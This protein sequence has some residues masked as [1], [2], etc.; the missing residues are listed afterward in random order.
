MNSL[1]SFSNRDLSWLAFNR[2]VLQE[3][4]DQTVPLMQRLRFL[5]IY[6]NNNDEFIKV[7]LANLMRLDRNAKTKKLVLPGKYTPREVISLINQD[8]NTT[9]QKFTE[10]YECLLAEM[11]KA[12]IFVIDETKLNTEQNQFCRKYFLDVVSRRLLPLFLHKTMRLPFLPDTGVY[13]AVCLESGATG[14]KR[15]AILQT[16][17]NSSCPRFVELPSKK[18]Q[19]DI[20]LLDDIIRLC[21]DD[22][23]FMFKYERATAYMFKLLRDASLSLENGL[24]K[25]LVEKM[26]KGLEERMHG[27]PVRFIYDREMP[28]EL[29]R[30]LVSKLAL[31]PWAVEPGRRYHMM[32][33]LM[34]FPVIR[35]DLEVSNTPPLLHPGLP[36]FS[37]IFQTVGAKDI[38]L[39]FPYQTF[40]HVID[41]LREAAISPKVKS[42]FITLYRVAADSKIVTALLSAAKNGKKVTVYVELLARF[43]EERNVSVIDILQEA[44]V[45]VLHGTPELKIHSKL[46]LVQGKSGTAGSGD[47]V[48]VGTGNFNED[49][50]KIYSDFGL[51]TSDPTIVSDARSIFTFLSNMHHRFECRKLLVSPFTLRQSLK[52]LMDNEIKNAKKGREAYIRIKCNGITDE[53]MAKHL[54]QAGKNGVSVRLIVRGP[55]IIKPQVPGLSENIQGISI[56]D[57][58][59][60]HARLFIF[61]NGGKET[62]Y[63]ASAD[64]MTRNLDRRVEV[65]AP[66]L[67]KN[68]KEELKTFFEIQW[69]DTTKARDLASADLTSY[70]HREGAPTVRAQEALYDYYV[71]DVNRQAKDNA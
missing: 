55:C 7:R 46:I 4:E 20:I 42:I 9:Q 37:S 21:L 39:A 34:S 70:V 38:L 52:K 23:F 3:A 61:C 68:L 64:L 19:H 24:H 10:I 26:E 18:G 6:S 11:A 29:V 71:N 60:E 44:G 45:T 13:F 16:P 48:Y 51:L 54:Y 58:Y 35:K 67:D 15:F 5:G 56:I 14:K 41:F 57:K 43:D 53:K 65:A 28:E 49:T 27:R 40:V 17:V 47:Y 32:R 31:K 36:P 2:R 33:H 30:T 66:I 22:I 8:V 50:A 1:N 62:M 63:I 69:S 59:L 25:S 12:K